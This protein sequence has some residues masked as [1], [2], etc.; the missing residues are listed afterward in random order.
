MIEPRNGITKQDV[1]SNHMPS[2]LHQTW[3]GGEGGRGGGGRGGRGEGGEGGGGEGGGGEGGGGGR[4]GGGG[5]GGR[6]GGGG[7]GEA[8]CLPRYDGTCL[9]CG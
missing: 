9:R 8:M 1:H 7:E 5:E 2:L 6:G 4:G 3:G